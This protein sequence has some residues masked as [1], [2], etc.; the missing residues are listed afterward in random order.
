MN[1]NALQMKEKVQSHKTMHNME[2]NSPTC[3]IRFLALP[4]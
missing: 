1:I 4:L 2:H 3:V